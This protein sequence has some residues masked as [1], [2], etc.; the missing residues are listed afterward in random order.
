MKLMECSETL[1][2]IHTAPQH[3]D[4]FNPSWQEFKNSV[5]VEIGLWYWRL[6]EVPT[7]SSHA[8]D[9]SRVTARRVSRI[10]NMHFDSLI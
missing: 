8:A 2:R 4:A 6:C 1:C 7:D 10:T 3:S 5:A 9:K